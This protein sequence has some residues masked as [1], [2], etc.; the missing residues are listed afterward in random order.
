MD[1]ARFIV[2]RQ[3]QEVIAALEEQ[4][5]IAEEKLA[6]DP[7]D[8]HQQTIV[9]LVRERLAQAR[10]T[11]DLGERVEAVRQQLEEA[12]DSA[13]QRTL[14]REHGIVEGTER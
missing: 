7:T 1:T 5:Q 11:S 10:D 9:E 3:R 12:Q 8:P 2:S 14:R 4:L 6:V 13:A